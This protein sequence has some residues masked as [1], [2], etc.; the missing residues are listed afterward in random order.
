VAISNHTTKLGY[1]VDALQEL[2]KI[3]L[4]QI[5]ISYASH[6]NSFPLARLIYDAQS[7]IRMEY[8]QRVIIKFLFNDALDP[9][10]IV[11]ELEAQFYED[12]Y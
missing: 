10:Q 2:M 9:R 6:R 11:A 4:N 7:P 3:S 5:Y 1:V 12:A 8:E